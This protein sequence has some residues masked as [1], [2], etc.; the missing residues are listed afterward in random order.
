MRTPFRKSML[1]L[2]LLALV[3]VAHAQPWSDDDA[4]GAGMMGYGHGPGMMGYGYESGMMGYGYG[5]GMMGYGYGSGMMGNGPG[6]GMGYGYGP[7][8][9]GDGYGAGMGYG[10][11]AGPGRYLQRDLGLTDAQ[12]KKLDAIHDDI[13]QAQWDL[14]GK[15]RAEMRTMRTLMQ[16]EPRDRPA[17]EASF[18]RMSD[19]RQQR[20]SMMLAAHDR[21]DAVLTPEQRAKAR[22]AFE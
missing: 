18:K 2:A 13:A 21:V 15:M 4:Y 17:I 10:Y 11:H 8:M 20:F 7:N 5:S 6:P 19:L 12:R 9:M 16:A 14:A 1:A 3:S 22:R